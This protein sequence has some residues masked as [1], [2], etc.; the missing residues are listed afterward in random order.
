MYLVTLK[1]VRLILET[2]VLNVLSCFLHPDTADK[3]EA[4]EGK[5]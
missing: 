4:D 5:D 3:E 1:N 2:D